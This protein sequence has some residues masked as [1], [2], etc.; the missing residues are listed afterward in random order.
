MGN[1]AASWG[2]KLSR[3][4][5][6][7]AYPITPQTHIVE[8]LSE[9]CSDGRLDAK[10]LK[11]E[12]EHSA[13]A[14]V[15]ASETTGVRSFTASSSNGLALMHEMLHWAAGARL[16]I[17][18]VNVNRA[19]APG[20]NIWADQGDSL[21]QRDTGWIQ[22]YVEDNQE[23]LDSVIQ[24]YRIAEQV[25]L[26]VMVC[27]DAFFL[28]HTYE[29][30]DIPDQESVDSWL[31]SFEPDNFLDPENPKAYYGLVM[32]DNYMEM[33]YRL[34]QAHEAAKRVVSEVGNSFGNHFGRPYDLV[35][36]I[37]CDDA[38]T[39]LITSSSATS[40]ARLVVDKLRD[41]GRKI[42][43]L[44]MRVFRPF[45]TEIVQEILGN[46]KTA[47]VIDRN[48]SWGKGGIFADEIKGAINNLSNRPMVYSFIAGLGGR[49]ITPDLIEDIVKQ[50]ENSESPATSSEWIG[51]KPFN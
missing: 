3:V 32:P 38:E 21:A 22:I 24:G 46:K 44:K 42:G 28:S 36:T 14:S 13:M 6:I 11:V 47:I 5:M 39:V 33:R 12:S 51:L 40:P 41:A 29:P 18:M 2:A 10:F 16:P 35:E 31:P 15:I 48:C 23:V 4:R 45:P 43:L 34:Q 7:A 9:M 27:Y 26:P 19:L 49:G 37:H 20:W 50:V 17:V 1:H 8:E 30:V 25:N